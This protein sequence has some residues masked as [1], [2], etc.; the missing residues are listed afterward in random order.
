MTLPGA[1]KPMARIKAAL[2]QA[3]SAF[4]AAAHCNAVGFHD[5]ATLS[6]CSQIAT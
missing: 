4:Q 1:A 5:G 2:D 3:G 6:D